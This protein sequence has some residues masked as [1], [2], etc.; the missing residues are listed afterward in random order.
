MSNSSV[1]QSMYRPFIHLCSTHLFIYSSQRLHPFIYSHHQPIYVP[2]ICRSVSHPSI[3]LFYVPSI[4]S[5]V[6]IYVPSIC[7]SVSHPSVHLYAIHL[8]IYSMYHPS[9][10]L[11]LSMPH[12]YVHLCP[13]HLF[14]YMPSISSSMSHPFVYGC[15][16]T[17]RRQSGLKCGVRGSGKEIRFFQAN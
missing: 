10:H 4:W 6:F 8:F 12:P 16:G 9:G 7:R 2:S 17:A 1:H 5:S 3:H 14:I 13:I 15:L 11:C